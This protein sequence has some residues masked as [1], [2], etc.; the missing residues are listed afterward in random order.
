MVDL[1][2]WFTRQEVG[3][4]TKFTTSGK[5]GG[6]PNAQGTAAAQLHQ[7]GDRGFSSWQEKNHLA[8]HPRARPLS[9]CG[10]EWPKELLLVSEG[11]RSA[12]V[13]EHRKVSRSLRRERSH[14]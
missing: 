5:P 2:L 8:R 14:Q 11:R 6:K 12:H 7:E 4:C 13:E 9:A 1:P 3:T 10:N